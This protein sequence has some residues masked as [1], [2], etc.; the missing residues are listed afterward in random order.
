[1][2]LEKKNPDGSGKNTSISLVAEMLRKKGNEAIQEE[3]IVTQTT[4]TIKEEKENNH[5]KRR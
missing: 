4:E 1:M 2:P 5:K 3:P